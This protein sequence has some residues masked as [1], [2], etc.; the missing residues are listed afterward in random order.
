LTICSSENLVFFM[1]PSLAEGPLSQSINW[2]ENRPA[3]HLLE[4]GEFFKALNS[5]N[6]ETISCQCSVV[7]NLTSLGVQFS[8]FI[9]DVIS[10]T[11]IIA[12]NEFA[13]SIAWRVIR[14][15]RVQKVMS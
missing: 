9:T 8:L 10:R 13:T 4:R 11:D 3:G 15:P 6:A 2:T 5:M 7:D 12:F 14:S 1:V